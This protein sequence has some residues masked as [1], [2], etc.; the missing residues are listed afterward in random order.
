MPPLATWYGGLPAI[1]DFLVVGP[2]SGH[3]RWRHLAT[4]ANG[5]AAVGCYTWRADEDSFRPFALDVLTLGGDR[6]REIT[7]FIMRGTEGL[8]REA[9]RRYPDEPPDPVKIEAVFERLGLP[10]RLD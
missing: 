2:L 7:S 4:R 5:Q 9:I 8:S 1:R 3:W 10:T 6:I